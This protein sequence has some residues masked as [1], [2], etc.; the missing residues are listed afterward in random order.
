MD[1]T[2]YIIGNGFDM[3]HGLP[4]GY[5]KF[6]YFFKNHNST[7]YNTFEEYVLAPTGAWNNFEEAFADIDTSQLF[8]DVL[9]YYP[10]PSSDDYLKDMGAPKREIERIMSNITDDVQNAFEAWIGKTIDPVI[11]DKNPIFKISNNKSKFINFNYTDTLQKLYGISDEN[12][13]HIH[14]KYGEDDLIFGHSVDPRDLI[15]DVRTTAEEYIDDNDFITNEI[16]NPIE[17]YMGKHFKDTNSVISDLDFK[18]FC[19]NAKKI[20]TLGHSLSQVD[21]PYLKYISEEVVD[22][23]AE[24]DAT[25]FAMDKDN[26]AA[27]KSRSLCFLKSIGVPDSQ[28]K[29]SDNDDYKI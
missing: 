21:R 4:T 8:I 5:D 26:L 20:I 29:S 13:I 2:L 14:G 25:A 7:A 16:C 27:E 22:K 18:D 1:E 24:W 6:Y 23:S 3:A 10:D 9:E 17:E 19:G 12:I 11:K 15:N 28:A